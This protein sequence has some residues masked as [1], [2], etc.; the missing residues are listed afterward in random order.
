MENI[1]VLNHESLYDKVDWNEDLETILNKLI[2]EKEGINPE[3]V[4]VEYIHKRREEKRG[5]V[6]S[7]FIVINDNF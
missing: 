2:A 7:C 3:D 6:H 1:T 5:F 4:T